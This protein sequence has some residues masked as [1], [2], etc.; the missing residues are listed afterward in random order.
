M[1]VETLKRTKHCR[2]I[3]ENPKVS[4]RQQ[5][6]LKS[7]RK[8]FPKHEKQTPENSSLITTTNKRPWKETTILNNKVS[9]YGSARQV[10]QHHIWSKVCVEG[11]S[12]RNQKKRSR[13]QILHLNIES[14]LNTFQSRFK[15]KRTENVSQG[16][17]K[18]TRD[19]LYFRIKN[20]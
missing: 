8:Y 6:K 3:F 4:I 7:W 10:P 14:R 9:L 19:G 15:R 20:K 13:S 16:D 11:H 12:K 5:K 17:K 1:Q 18:T 2:P